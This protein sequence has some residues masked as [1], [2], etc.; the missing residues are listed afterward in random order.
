[1]NRSIGIKQT[2]RTLRLWVLAALMVWTIAPDVAARTAGR[3]VDSVLYI[4]TGTKS[5]DPY[6]YAGRGDFH[7]VIFEKPCRVRQLGTHAFE[8]CGRLREINLPAGLD[9]IA[10]QAFAYDSLLQVVTIPES[11][12]HI[13]SN[14]FAFCRK[15]RTVALPRRLKELES[16]AFCECSDLEEITFPAN[17]N[18]LGEMILWGCRKMRNVIVPS[19]T[20]PT[21][22]CNSQLFDLEENFIYDRCTLTVPPGSERRYAAAP[23]WRFFKHIQSKTF[24]NKSSK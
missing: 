4:P 22:D 14:A 8:S 2:L 23:G 12:R 3:V 6:Q 5:I 21:F 16:Y 20:P 9:D 10:S 1:M 11:V 19:V 18:M 13:G 7:T 17:S 15:L 24:Q